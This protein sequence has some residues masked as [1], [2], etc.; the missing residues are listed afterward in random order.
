MTTLLSRNFRY[1]ILHPVRTSRMARIMRRW[2]DAQPQVCEYC[3]KL[4]RRS[5]RQVHH[6][7]PLWAVPEAAEN[8][9]NFSL[10]HGGHCH[11]AAHLGNYAEGYIE[12]WGEVCDVIR[13]KWR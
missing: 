10:V 2:A 7:L 6:C 1:A 12:N 3:G 9:E 13:R 5:K 11:Q 4:V 8:P